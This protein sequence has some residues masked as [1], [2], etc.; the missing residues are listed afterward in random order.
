MISLFIEKHWKNNTVINRIETLEA[1]NPNSQPN[2]NN[3]SFIRWQGRSLEELGKAINLLLSLSLATSGF[4]IVKLLDSD[5]K[6][7]LNT[8]QTILLIGGL[9]LTSITI[10]V[11]LFLIY[12]RLLSF[13]RTTQIA[14]K[15]EKGERDEIEALRKE[16]KEIDSHT[17]KLFKWSII[18]FFISLLFTIS[19][20]VVF[21]LNA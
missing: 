10:L 4:L 12:N 20:F 18:F 15:R 21:F 8:L 16:V 13:R 3:E 5:F 6:C 2:M 7:E 19:G 11:L 9:V 1:A 14:R 17:W